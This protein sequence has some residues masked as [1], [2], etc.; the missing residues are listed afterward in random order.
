S[1][2]NINRGKVAVFQ[3]FERRS[4]AGGDVADLVGQ[5]GLFDGGGAVA[6]AD[7]GDG[8][9]FGGSVGDGL[10]NRAGAFGELGFFEY[11]HGAVPD[12][13]FGFGDLGAVGR[14]RLGANVEAALVGGDVAAFN[15][16]GLGG[17]DGLGNDGIGR[18]FQFQSGF[19]E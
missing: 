3:V 12:D 7:D 14:A 16:R 4:A 11:A 19:G 18:E 8:A 9:V 10:R 6:A 17:V 15:S 1:V 13:G 5:T 2:Q